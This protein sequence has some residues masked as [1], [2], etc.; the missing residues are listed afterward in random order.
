MI[1]NNILKNKVY[2]ETEMELLT[3]RQ[4]LVKEIVFSKKNEDLLQSVKEKLKK[5]N[6]SL[7]KLEVHE[8]EH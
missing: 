2:R 7:D 8:N 6:K 4:F 5:I 3:L 1:V